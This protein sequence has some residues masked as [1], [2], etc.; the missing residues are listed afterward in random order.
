MVN[1][2]QVERRNFENDC[3]P[4]A[5][6]SLRMVDEPAAEGE[7]CFESVEV[8]GA[9]SGSMHAH[10]QR[11]VRRV[12]SKCAMCLGARLIDGFSARYLSVQKDH[13]VAKNFSAIQ[14]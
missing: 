7:F 6:S 2:K 12:P 4:T 1:D 11:W 13:N 9:R 5:S 3:S 8:S 10:G 14:L